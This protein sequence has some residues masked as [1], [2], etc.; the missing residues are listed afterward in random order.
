[1]G[2]VAEVIVVGGGIGGLAAACGI[3]KLG[4]RAMC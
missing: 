3:A 1:M 4:K 2:N